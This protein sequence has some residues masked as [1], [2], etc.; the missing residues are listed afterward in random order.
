MNSKIIF[1][2]L[3]ISC[4]HFYC[5]GDNVSPVIENIIAEPDSIATGG[6]VQLICNASDEEDNSLIYLWDCALGN[7]S[8][9]NEN[10]SAIWIAPN[11]TGYFSISCEVSDSNNGSAIQTIN[12]KVL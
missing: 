10:D 3:F 11:E 5:A 6:S 8:S 12:V 2:I 9:S 4:F 1:L 7:I